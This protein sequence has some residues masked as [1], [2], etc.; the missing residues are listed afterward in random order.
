MNNHKIVDTNQL[1]SKFTFSDISEDTKNKLILGGLSFAG[2]AMAIGLNKIFISG[3]KINPS[4]IQDD[5]P[6][7]SSEPM[8]NEADA[9][10]EHIETSESSINNETTAEATSASE[11]VENVE[12]VYSITFDSE[13]NFAVSIDDGMDF[14]TAFAQAR[15]EVGMGGFFN[16][17]DNSY[18]TYTMEEWNN[19]SPD[20]QQAFFAEVSSKTQL[21][22]DDWTVEENSSMLDS[23]ITEDNIHDEDQD[24]DTIDPSEIEIEESDDAQSDLQVASDQNSD[25]ETITIVPPT[26]YG[27]ADINSDNIVDAIVIDTNNDGKAD[28][29]ALDEDFDGT[30]ES[31]MINEDG[32]EDLDVFIIDQ[33]ADGIDDTDTIEEIADIVEMD[34]FIVIEEDDPSLE[35]LDFIDELID[36]E[37]EEIQEDDSSMDNTF[38]DPGL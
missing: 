30:F 22:V 36:I 25:V 6:L 10:E 33:G 28:L 27:S 37:E 9:V 31:F 5:A 15:E 7:A 4:T 29:L 16:W 20:N 26:T 19:M 38:D 18:S 13:A 3:D 24:F 35:G 2:I 34:D 8:V 1:K 32:D 17:N 12:P 11:E 14:E 23:Q 21:N